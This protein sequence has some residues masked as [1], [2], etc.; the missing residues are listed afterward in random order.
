MQS[1]ITDL[2][3]LRYWAHPGVDL[4]YVT[5]PESIE[6]VEKLVGPGTRRVGAAADLPR[7]PDAAHP[8]RRPRGA[9]RARP[10]PRSSSSPAAAGGSATSR[11]RS[12][13]PSPATTPSSS[14][15]P[16]AT[17]S[18]ARSSSSASA[19]TSRS[20]ILGFTEQMSDWMAAADAMIHA[21]AGLTV[22]EA[23]I[24]GCP[25]VSY[26][27]SAGHLRANNAAF[28]RFGLAEVARSEHELE[29]V[30]RHVTRERRSPDS[31]FASLPSIASRALER[32][33]AGAAA[34]GLAP[35]LR[36]RRR[37]GLLRRRGDRADALGGPV[38]EPA[39]ASPKP[40]TSRIHIGNEN[41]P[42]AGQ[43]GGAG[44]RQPAVGEPQP[45]RRNRGE[46]SLLDRAPRP[47]L[48]LGAGA[49]AHAGPALAPVVPAIGNALAG[50][51]AP[52]GRR[53][54]R[55]HLRR[56]PAPAG[57]A[58]GAGGAARGRRRGDLLPRRRAGRAAAGAGRPR[59]SPPATGSS[60]TATATATSCG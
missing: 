12:A 39:G 14:A 9:R 3:G 25:V 60:C 24:R 32:A 41:E 13:R 31:S 36:A 43:A 23:H 55:P 21:T 29:S 20:A 57:H 42:S 17:R 28:E 49:V 53:G 44:D 19:T 2:A 5:H 46:P 40:V 52:G 34:A 26:G 33:A 50:R 56:R 1:A 18:P 27:F 10:R 7:V 6:E 54:R 51:P 59:S 37:R 47:R 4:H 35:A 15:S 11:A 45:T 22:L 16:A 38:G 30:L 58:G 8:P 48:G